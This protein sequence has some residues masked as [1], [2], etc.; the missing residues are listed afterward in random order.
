M[1][2]PSQAYSKGFDH[3]PVAFSKRII[4]PILGIFA[5]GAITIILDREKIS[6]ALRT[7]DWRVIP[8][9]LLFTATSYFC[10][11][12]TYTMVAQMWGVRMPRRDLTE[13]CFV[14]TSLNH[15]VRSGG[16]AG[17]SVRYLLMNQRGIPF[18]TVMTSSLVHYYL[19][20][21]DMLAMLPV[22][23][24]YLLVYTDI[25]YTITILLAAMTVLVTL[26]AIGY[27][28]FIFSQK[29]RI[30]LA[31]LSTRLGKFFLRRD[32]SNILLLQ[33]KVA[34]SQAG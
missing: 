16:V 12:Y 9:A 34:K 1:L 2:D 15:V 20:S 17:Y 8:A 4:W 3:R 13:I 23:F 33:R 29:M 10:V 26:L 22:A 24:A 18:N 32:Y 31:G 5:L 14:T 27:T 30:V 21:L 7:A 11:S 19:T 28:S 6:L 25:P